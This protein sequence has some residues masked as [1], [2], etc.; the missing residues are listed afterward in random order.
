M[1]YYI[2]VVSVNLNADQ[3]YF[4]SRMAEHWHGNEE[5]T[6]RVYETRYNNTPRFYAYIVNE[7]TKRKNGNQKKKKTAHTQHLPPHCVFF[8]ARGRC[9]GW[10]YYNPGNRAVFWK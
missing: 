9:Q 6:R 3:G 1:F 7:I 4:R 8:S 5:C 10:E 2:K